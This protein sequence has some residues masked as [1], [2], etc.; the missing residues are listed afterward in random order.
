MNTWSEVLALILRDPVA[1]WPVLVL[2]GV[3]VWAVF[4]FA[5]WQ[6]GKRERRKMEGLEQHLRY[7]KQK[8]A[9]LRG[10]YE[11]EWHART[12]DEKPEV[13]ER[14]VDRT[15]KAF[16][17]LY[18]ATKETDVTLERLRSVYARNVDLRSAGRDP[19]SPRARRRP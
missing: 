15:K 8:E 7:L 5:Y 3:T 16:N 1:L 4:K 10:A 6:R 11:A 12:N 19:T 2:Y 14:T 9:D 13:I 18:Q 17:E